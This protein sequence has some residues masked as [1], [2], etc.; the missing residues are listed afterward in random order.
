MASRLFVGNLS[1]QVT[2][3]ELETAF[4]E[5][6]GINAS[7]PV[8][9]LGRPRGFGFVDVEADKV[10]DA[11][12]AMN[13]QPLHGRDITVN[14]AKPRE[15]RGPRPPRESGGYGGSAGGYGGGYDSGPGS[16][17]GNRGNRD[18]RGG[19]RDKRY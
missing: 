8:N 16:D 2:E 9:E 4:R 15:T 18:S 14:E 3:E 19:G 5:F 17:R 11:V 13:G 7:I 10:Q 1:F 12:A 6:G